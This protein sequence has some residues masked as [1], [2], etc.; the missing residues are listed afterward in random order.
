MT[1][2]GSIGGAVSTIVTCALGRAPSAAVQEA[3]GSARLGSEQETSLAR[4]VVR[5]TPPAHCC[6]IRLVVDGVSPDG[7]DAFVW[8]AAGWASARRKN[9]V[10][11]TLGE[12]LRP[13]KDSHSIGAGQCDRRLHRMVR[14]P[15]RQRQD[16][17]SGGGPLCPARSH[18]VAALCQVGA[19]IYHR[20]YTS[21][22]QLATCSMSCLM[23][24]LPI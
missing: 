4:H 13:P 5:S 1:T 20:R 6:D 19:P 24:M 12:R 16:R 23:G 7:L 15:R 8:L 9:A 2:S 17:R 14:Q 10:E 22:V 21:A 3:N 11:A 18:S